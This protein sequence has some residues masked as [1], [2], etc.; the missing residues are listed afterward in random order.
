MADHPIPQAVLDASGVVGAWFHDHWA[1]RLSLSGPFA[2]LLG[3]DPAVAAGGVP[4]ADFLAGT[5][6]EDRTRIES[7]L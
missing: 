4:L 3:L 1:G 7:Y 2:G 6:P 5:H